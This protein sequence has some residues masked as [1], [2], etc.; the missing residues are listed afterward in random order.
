[1]LFIPQDTSFWDELSISSWV[2]KSQRGFVM[3]TAN[4][5]PPSY[6]NETVIG[7]NSS[8]AQ[9]WYVLRQNDWSQTYRYYFEGPVLTA[10]DPLPHPR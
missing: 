9:Y 6:S 1:M 2:P 3:G 7:W 5:V 8:D 4:G 10:T